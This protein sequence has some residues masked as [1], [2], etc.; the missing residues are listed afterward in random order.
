MSDGV[1]LNVNVAYQ[2]NNRVMNVRRAQTVNHPPS[3]GSKFTE[4]SDF[5]QF[6]VMNTPNTFIDPTKTRLNFSYQVTDISG[7]GN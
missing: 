3:N 1:G 7:P 6:R 2:P 4:Q 5:L